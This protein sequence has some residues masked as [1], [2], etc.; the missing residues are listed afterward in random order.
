MSESIE[1]R[2]LRE[3]LHRKSALSMG[4]K[5]VYVEAPPPEL[6]RAVKAR[7]RRALQWLGPA[8]LAACIAIGLMGGLVI[9]VSK[10]MDVAVK[11]E[12]HAKEINTPPVTVAID[13][14]SLSMENAAPEAGPT[15]E[16][17]GREQWLAKIDALKK[18]GKQAEADAEL[19][20]FRAAYPRESK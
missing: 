10:F 4:Y 8:A 17:P 13:A 19:A 18:E 14:K 12:R 7:A 9:G 11:A 2:E 16:Q 20:R 15:A 5:K 3:Y 1:D 6:D